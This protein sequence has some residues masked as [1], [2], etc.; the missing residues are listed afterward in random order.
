MEVGTSSSKLCFIN[1]HFLRKPCVQ[2]ENLDSST[3]FGR[4][5]FLRKNYLKLI[6]GSRVPAIL[7]R[8]LSEHALLALDVLHWLAK[9]AK[10]PPS[11]DH[12]SR[13]LHSIF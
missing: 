7:K 12:V 1:H 9:V 13:Y 5:P 10:T 2:G 8:V 11:A 3:F 4:K 6:V